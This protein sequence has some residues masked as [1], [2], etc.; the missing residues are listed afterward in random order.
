M[1]KKTDANKRKTGNYYESKVVEYLKEKGLESVEQNY[2]TDIGE[3][4][5]IVK[6]KDN[7]TLIFVEVKSKEKSTGLSAFEAVDRRKQK[8]I[9]RLAKHYIMM[10]EIKNCFVRFDVAGVYTA[11]GKVVEIDYLKDAFQE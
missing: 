6:E 7:P 8:T 1:D 4:D 3:I 5:I 2:Y 10:K 9:I 11:H